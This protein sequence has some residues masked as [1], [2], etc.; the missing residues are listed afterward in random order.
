MYEQN[1]IINKIEG[2]KLCDNKHFHHLQH[3]MTAY[4]YKQCMSHTRY[5]YKQYFNQK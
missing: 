4:D 3:N 1:K 5:V 2:K